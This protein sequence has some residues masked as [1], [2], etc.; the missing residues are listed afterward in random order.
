MPSEISIPAEMVASTMRSI[1]CAAALAVASAQAAA[2]TPHPRDMTFLPRRA[3]NTS[4]SG[5]PY[6]PFSTDGR[7][8]VDSKGDAITWTGINWPGSGMSNEVYAHSIAD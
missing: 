8:I 2:L 1:F 6:G 7:D 5:W 4:A 3:E